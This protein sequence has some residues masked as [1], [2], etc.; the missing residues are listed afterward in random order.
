MLI[1][2]PMAI[3]NGERFLDKAISSMIS[4]S[5][6]SWE[7]ICVDDGST[8]NS[9]TI[10]RKYAETDSRIVLVQQSNLGAPRARMNAYRR[11]KGDFVFTGLDQDDYVESCFIE[12][13][14]LDAN[15]SGSEYV[16]CDWMLEQPDGQFISFFS[17][18]G[19]S[20]G[21]KMT[22]VEAF[23]S[24]FPWTVHLVGLWCRRLVDEFAIDGANAFNNYDS[25]E[26]LGRKIVLAANE[27]YFGSAKYFHCRNP[28]S[29]TTKLS[30]RRLSSLD[31]NR[32]LLAL[33]EDQ[34]LDIEVRR[35][36]VIRQR[37]D[38]AFLFSVARDIL[39]EADPKTTKDTLQLLNENF[40]IFRQD[41]RRYSNKTFADALKA[42]VIIAK[43]LIRHSK[44]RLKE[45]IKK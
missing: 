28:D 2:V 25:D 3:Y 1:S 44:M 39:H 29:I 20:F 12:K 43:M 21:Q 31:T 30:F 41:I 15:R 27:V 32:R 9:A 11:A 45:V 36:I 42:E 6:S 13:L 17:E 10:V 22:G 38:L 8:D 24:T 16:L 14:I 18:H 33:A 26:F 40:K 37:N 35:R 4:Q 19:R 23:S 5:V 34:N 7:L